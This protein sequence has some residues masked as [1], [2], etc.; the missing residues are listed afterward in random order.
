M[1]WCTLKL[2]STSFLFTRQTFLKPEAEIRR[3]VNLELHQVLRAS[4]SEGLTLGP[5]GMRKAAAVG[6]A[7]ALHKRAAPARGPGTVSHSGREEL[8]SAPAPSS[9]SISP[10]EKIG[11][12]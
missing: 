5:A 7:A 12:K 4:I 11:S 3:R 8:C 2:S 10:K 6:R 9:L 1:G